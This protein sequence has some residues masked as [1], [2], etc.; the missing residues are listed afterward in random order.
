MSLETLV[1][2]YG[3]WALLV[4]TFFEGETI[5]IIGGLTAHLGYLKLPIVMLVAF[6]G[7]FSGDQFY[8]FVG[9][10]KGMD[11]LAEHPKWQKKVHRVHQLTERYHDFIMLGFRFVYG[12]R[13]MT[14]FVLAM[15]KRVR[16]YRF[17]ILNA[18]GAAVWSIAIAGGGYLFGD[19]LEIVIRDI[20][21]YQIGV[22][23]II[24]VAGM[25]FWFVHKYREGRRP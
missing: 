15:N 6:I 9:R 8:F 3:Y 18:I 2:T 5:L 10:L 1:S 22:M 20:K 7:S 24:S 17:I 4:G 11:L 16:T 14:P 12:M 19:A 23:L 25:V 21:R 13:I